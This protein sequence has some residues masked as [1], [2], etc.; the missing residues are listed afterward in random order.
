MHLGA[1]DAI[2]SGNA[3]GVCFKKGRET[4]LSDADINACLCY[5]KG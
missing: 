3:R 2:D 1:W 4:V 5:I